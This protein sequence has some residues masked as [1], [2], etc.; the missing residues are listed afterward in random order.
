MNELAGF[1]STGHGRKFMALLQQIPD[2]IKAANRIA[3]ALEKLTPNERL[4]GEE[5]PD[6]FKIERIKNI[7]P[8]VERL[9][10]VLRPVI[11]ISPE[12]LENLLC[13]PDDRVGPALAAM[14]KDAVLGNIFNGTNKAW[15]IFVKPNIV[16][17]LSRGDGEGAWVVVE[18]LVQHFGMEFQSNYLKA[19]IEATKVFGSN[20]TTTTRIVGRTGA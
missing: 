7:G 17:T 20:C 14:N 3:S 10:T 8:A 4:T 19:C 15:T 1:F 9:S 2:G 13:G 6:W 11:Y 12:S 5:T 18:M 16:I